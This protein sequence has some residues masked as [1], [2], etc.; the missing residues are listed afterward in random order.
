VLGPEEV[1]GRRYCPSIDL[2]FESAA[3]AVG[4]RA[5]GVILTGMGSDGRRGIE[6]IK[7]AGGLTLAESQDSA[8]VYGMPEEAIATGRVDEVLPIDRVA[9]RLARFARGG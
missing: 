8:V 4:D 1:A 6:A 9:E 7:S 2:L 5:C 3:R